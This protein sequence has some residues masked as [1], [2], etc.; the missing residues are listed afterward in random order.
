MK[1]TTLLYL[2]AAVVLP[3]AAHAADAACQAIL[4][5]GQA[6]LRAPTVHDINVL[7][8]ESGLTGEFI[9]IGPDA[10]IKADRGWRKISPALL[11]T[12]Q[13]AALDGLTMSDCKQVGSDHPT[14]RDVRGRSSRGK[15]SQGEYY[16]HD[17]CSGPTK[18]RVV[19]IRCPYQTV[20]RSIAT[21][22]APFPETL[23]AMLR[24]L[25]AELRDAEL[26]AWHTALETDGAL[27]ADQWDL[28]QGAINRTV[29]RELDAEAAR[30]YFR[31]VDLRAGAY[32][33]P[34]T[35]GESRF[36]ANANPDRTLQHRRAYLEVHSGGRPNGKLVKR[37]PAE[38]GPVGE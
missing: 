27:P 34:W 36:I 8:A 21:A 4:N 28:V 1:P 12:M 7:D 3:N 37:W 29:R 24:E 16:H 25:P 35:M 2:A 23:Y 38:D 9:K 18:P 6:K 13:T 19:E 10:W 31:S 17:G 32:R 14:H 20:G 30:A 33:E 22:V 15:L 11:K 26:G 5:A